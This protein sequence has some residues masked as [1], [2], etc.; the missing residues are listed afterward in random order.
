M[1]SAIELPKDEVPTQRYEAVTPL[2]TRAMPKNEDEF[3]TR[4]GEFLDLW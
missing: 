1:E 3:P 2:R 4:E